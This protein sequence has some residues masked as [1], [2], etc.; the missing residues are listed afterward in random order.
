MYRSA[1]IFFFVVLSFSCAQ[2]PEDTQLPP[3]ILVSPFVGT[4]KYGFPFYSSELRINEDHTFSCFDR[5]CTACCY[6]RGKWS[7]QGS[8]M[9]LNSLDEYK[10]REPGQA[11]SIIKP[12]GDTSFVYY[13]NVV[14]QLMIDSLYEVRCGG[15]ETARI[16]HRS[17]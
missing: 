2:Q 8:K 5:G 12:A 1:L 15:I 6:T 16:Y 7:M 14:M 4:W 10:Q 17:Y 13:N 9:I 11:G 3:N